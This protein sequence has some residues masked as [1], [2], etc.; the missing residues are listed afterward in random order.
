M[1]HIFMTAANLGCSLV[2]NGD[3]TKP[4][5]FVEFIICSFE[6]VYEAD[7]LNNSM[8]KSVFYTDRYQ[9]SP[10]QLRELVKS[11]SQ[12][13]DYCESAFDKIVTNEKLK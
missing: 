7:N 5:P 11:L 10:N 9:V 8:K 2:S 12:Y 4:S 3:K 1:R 6:H 13:A